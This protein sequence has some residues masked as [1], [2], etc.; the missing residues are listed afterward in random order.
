MPE[1]EGVGTELEGVA[2]SMASVEAVAEDGTVEAFRMGGVDA[3]LVGAAR[4]GREADFQFS[5]RVDGQDLIFG[6]GGFPLVFVY[7]LPGAVVPVRGDREVDPAVGTGGEVA[8][9]GCAAIG[10]EGGGAGWGS[11]AVWG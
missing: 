1:G 5:I 3:E 8:G 4:M 9:V 11:A 7:F 10:G 2:L 6:A